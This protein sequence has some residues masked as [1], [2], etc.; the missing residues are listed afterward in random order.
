MRQDERCKAANRR[1]RAKC[2]A[3]GFCIIEKTVPHQYR[4]EIRK[5]VGAFLRVANEG[6]EPHVSEIEWSTPA[7]TPL[8]QAQVRPLCETPTKSDMRLDGGKVGKNA[9]RRERHAKNGLTRM[10]FKLKHDFREIVSRYI[11][12]MVLLMASQRLLVVGVGKDSAE[13]GPAALSAKSQLPLLHA[14]PLSPTKKVSPL[15]QM[16]TADASPLFDDIQSA[17][18]ML[19]LGV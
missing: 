1:H 17:Q 10:T 19:G 15:Q 3:Q 9:G 6:V 18:S 5:F 8:S 12:R 4:A 14:V 11:D 16:D 13:L 7:G 2:K